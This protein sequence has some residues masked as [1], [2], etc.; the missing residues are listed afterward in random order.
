MISFY[1]PRSPIVIVATHLDRVKKGKKEKVAEVEEEFFAQF[2]RY[3]A[4]GSLF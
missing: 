2:A 3:K 1:A 4:R